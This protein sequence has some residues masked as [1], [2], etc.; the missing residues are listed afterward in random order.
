M[1]VP[2]TSVV[3]HKNSKAIKQKLSPSWNILVLRI[4]VPKGLVYG[5]NPI[6]TNIPCEKV[7]FI[8]TRLSNLY[9]A[10]DTPAEA[11]WFLGPESAVGDA[12][13]RRTSNSVSENSGLVM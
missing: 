9:N 13:L 12:A 2:I 10:V 5:F 8:G 1:N 7:L 6:L 11:A 4:R 3:T